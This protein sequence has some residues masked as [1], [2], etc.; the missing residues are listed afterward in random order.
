MSSE[1]IWDAE[2]IRFMEGHME[3]DK[4]VY[5]AGLAGEVFLKGLK[6]G[7]IFASKCP[8]CGATYLPARSFCE[9]CFSEITEHFEVS[10]NGEVDTFTIQY[11]DK[12]GKPLEKPVIWAVIKFYG[13]EGG[14]LHKLGEVEPDEVYIGMPVEPVFKPEYER[15]GSINDIAYF[16]PSQ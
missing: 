15:K 2:K 14:I 1:R 16:K 3:A 13:I 7:K 8:K 12:D 5:T 10:E 9:K 4:Y 6:E 11:V